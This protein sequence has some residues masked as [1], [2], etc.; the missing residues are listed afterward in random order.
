MELD[1]IALKTVDEKFPAGN[2]SDWV[3]CNAIVNNLNFIFNG[4]DYR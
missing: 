3:L 2:Y 4:R 1:F